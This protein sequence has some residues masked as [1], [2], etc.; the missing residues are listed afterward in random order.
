MKAY[1]IYIHIPFCQK[2]CSYCDFNTY[3]GRDSLIPAYI[4]ALV[5]EIEC[6]GSGVK[7][8][9]PVHTIYF[10]GGTPS[11]LTPDQF[12]KTLSTLEDVFSLVNPIEITLEANPG[13]VS[14]S[15]LKDLR[16]IGLNRISLGVQSARPRELALLGRQHD[17]VDVINAVRWARQAGFNNLSLDLIFGIPGQTAKDWNGSLRIAIDLAPDHFSL[18]GLTIEAD[19]LMNDWSS[20]GLI[21]PQNPD[22]AAEM[23]E[24]AN[25]LLEEAS[26]QQYEIS[27]WARCNSVKGSTSVGDQISNTITQAAERRSNVLPELAYS[28]QHN[29]QYWRNLPYLGF[30]AGAHGFSNGFRTVNVL[31]P[32]EYIHSIE[33]GSEGNGY[34]FPQGPGT[35]E[36]IQIDR[37]TEIQEYMI[38]G[39]RLTLEGVADSEFQTRF[40]ISLREQFGNEIRKIIDWGLLEW[41]GERLRLTPRGRLLGNRVFSEFI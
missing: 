35:S 6:L 30:G 17:F 40:G 23:Y 4:K 25:E 39:L 9:V 14:L 24:M 11:L 38:M 22:L 3:A 32:E 34:S 2:R 21:P 5:K 8:A 37:A 10:G 12:S 13:T 18:Y 28:C 36:L 41:I 27:N 7:E 19:T 26:Y 15:Y 33:T 31:R 29:L 1:S 16:A 20:R